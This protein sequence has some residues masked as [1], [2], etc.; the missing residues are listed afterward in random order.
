MNDEFEDKLGQQI[1][2]SLLRE[3]S[4]IDVPPVKEQWEDFVRRYGVPKK[5]TNRI[6]KV[7]LAAAAVVLLVI[8]GSFL[9]PA[10][11]TAFGER[12]FTSIKVFLGGSL[13][14]VKTEQKG[15]S[16]PPAVE[17]NEPP[18]EKEVT[19]DEVEKIVYFN[20]A[21]PHYLPQGTELKKVL[22]TQTTGDTYSIKMEY[23]VNNQPFMLIQNNLVAGHN[24]SFL[25][26]SDDAQVNKIDI[27]GNEGHL[28]KTKDGTLIL[29]WVM[30]GLE[31]ELIG[32]TEEDDLIKVAR[33]VA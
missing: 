22:L 5:R 27:N 8:S 32:K 17:Q 16:A 20:I 24:G 26:D 25:Y 33:S 19:L 13:Y 3:A 15:N 9:R 30:R 11:A 2:K 7:T 14:N 6:R 12:L 18:S 31:L 29:R 1:R 10:T 4:E 23:S 28:L 21:R